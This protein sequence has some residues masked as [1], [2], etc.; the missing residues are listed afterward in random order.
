L[1]IESA[2]KSVLRPSGQWRSVIDFFCER[3]GRVFKARDPAVCTEDGIELR[4]LAARLPERG[5]MIGKH[6]RVNKKVGDGGMCAIY[7]ATDLT[8]DTEVAVKVLHPELATEPGQSESMLYE[9]SLSLSLDDENLVRCYDGGISRNGFHFMVMD[10]LEGRTLAQLLAIRGRVCMEDAA[11]I[12]IGAARGLHAV[13]QSGHVHRDVKPENIFINGNATTRTIMAE[14][15]KLMDLGVAR[16]ANAPVRSMTVYGTPEYMSPEQVSGQSLDRRSDLYSLGV[17]L[18]EML[19][20]K[21]CFDGTDAREVMLAH[22]RR[23]PPALP[24]SLEVTPLG[25]ILSGIVTS[26]LQKKPDDRPSSALEISRLI[27]LADIRRNTTSRL[28]FSFFETSAPPE[29][30]LP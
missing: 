5:E 20:G 15:V 14:R 3:C 10:L 18:Y 26:L 2:W 19:T 22:I 8:N 16:P 21:P 28:D 7:S 29:H 11:E 13:H 23:Q 9:V 24:E 25:R 30:R 1:Q 4:P 17:V 6:Y 27:P 12:F